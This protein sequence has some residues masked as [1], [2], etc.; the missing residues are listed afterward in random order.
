MVS[1]PPLAPG[2]DQSERG[3]TLELPSIPDVKTN[4]G[5]LRNAEWRSGGG[6]GGRTCQQQGWLLCNTVTQHSEGNMKFKLSR[7]ARILDTGRG[8]AQ[9]TIDAISDG[10]LVTSN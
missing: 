1:T 7:T 2:S 6:G 4:S 5:F 9:Q 3:L 10:I 8:K